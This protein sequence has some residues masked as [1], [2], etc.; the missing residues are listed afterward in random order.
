MTLMP[1]LLDPALTT[2]FTKDTALMQQTDVPIVTV[3]GTYREDLKEGFGLPDDPFTPDVVF[4]RAHFSMTVAMLTAAWGNHRQ[5]LK[6][7]AVDPTNYVSHDE[8][9][10]I[11]LTEQIGKTLARHPFLKLLKDLVDRFGRQKLPILTSITPPLLHLTQHIPAGQPILSLHVAAGNILAGLGKTVI[12]VITD[13]HVRD[14]YVTNAALPTMWFCVFDEQTKTAFLEKA[15]L[16][17]IQADPNRIIITGPPVDPR[18][19]RASDHKQ[20][21]RSGPLNLCLT[22]GGLGTNKTELRQLLQQLLPELRRRPS[23]YRVL[24]YAGTQRDIAQMVRELASEHHVAISDL[25]D[26]DQELRL[27]YHPQITDANEL[28][29]KF[30]FPW[31]HGFIT[32]PSGDMAYDAAASGSFLLTLKEWGEWEHN[33]RAVFEQRGVARSADPAHIVSQLQA[34]TAAQGQASSWAERAMHA[35]HRL[36]PLFVTG[37]KNILKTVEM[38]KN[39]KKS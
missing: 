32:K 9:S 13:P 38:I 7:W 18:V 35:T 28:L 1:S 16:H 4:S 20:A 11:Q 2:A 17:G 39:L 27:I 36:D 14:E 23:P 8:W 21:W 10:K 19:I 5:P 30:G 26:S 3:S 25:A 12:Q 6:A 29:I 34:L 15:A 31:A 22:T 24:V 33:V 37:C